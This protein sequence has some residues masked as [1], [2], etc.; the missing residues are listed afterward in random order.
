MIILTPLS[1]FQVPIMAEC[2]SPDIFKDKSVDE[3]AA[4]EIL[5]GNRQKKLADLFKVE[6]NSVASPDITINGDVSKA[7]LIGFG[8]KSG[9]I[10]IN[11]NVGMHLGEKMAGGKITLHGN[12]GG[13]A[14][15]QMKG[16]LVEIHGNAGDYLAASY[17]GSDV[18]MRGGKLIVHGN[19]GIHAGIYMK[20]GVIKIEGSAG[21]YLG[22][23]MRDGAIHVAKDTGNRVGALMIGGKI[24]VSGFLAEVL[25]SFT[26]DS[27]R[28][29]VKLDE[30]ETVSGPF[31]VFLGDLTENGKGKLFVSK[32]NNS[33]L[34]SIYEKYL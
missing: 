33:H 1:E 29:K 2:I 19:V 22:F 13:W 26:I 23:R 9:E 4:L 14:G 27:I 25:P 12:A 34:S 8:M 11:G 17:R 5:E 6:E 18:G 24:I 28:P 21:Q 16:G 32:V 15:A 30:T 20:G 10:V 3:I 31:Y 7:K